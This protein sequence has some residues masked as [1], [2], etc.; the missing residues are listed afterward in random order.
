MIFLKF[1][2]TIILIILTSMIII[3][4]TLMLS[5]KDTGKFWYIKLIIPFILCAIDVYLWLYPWYYIV[6]F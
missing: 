2:L 1:I 5:S 4:S 6:M 3:L